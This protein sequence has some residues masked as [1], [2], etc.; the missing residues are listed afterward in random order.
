MCKKFFVKILFYVILLI[1]ILAA[2]WWLLCKPGYSRVLNL[3]VEE[4]A[5]SEIRLSAEGVKIRFFRVDEGDEVRW[6]MSH[7]AYRSGEE[8]EADDY[9][10]ERLLE[11]LRQW[12]IEGVV[13]ADTVAAG[14]GRVETGVSGSATSGRLSVYTKGF[15]GLNR[16]VWSRRY[17]CTDSAAYLRESKRLYNRLYNPRQP[18]EEGRAA[19]AAD[20]TLCPK[21]WR[22]KWIS[23][24]HYYEIARAEWQSAAGVFITAPATASP[25]EAALSAFRSVR[26]DRFATSQDS[27]VLALALSRPATDRL[28]ILTTG[29]DSI[30]LSIYPLLDTLGQADLFRICGLLETRTAALSTKNTHPQH[31]TVFLSHQPID[32]LKAALLGSST[33]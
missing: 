32:R 1:F 17:L 5:V 31:D 15:C 18:D 30:S 16:L 2:G 22:N 3:P 12:E 4:G 25:G 10:V 29:S 20:L 11:S 28:T 7:S 19:L 8:T 6:L 33:R 21:H 27:S 14:A 26:F 13:A 23:R 9:A 24:Y